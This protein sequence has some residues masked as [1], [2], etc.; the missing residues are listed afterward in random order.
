MAVSWFLD[1]TN[2]G[3]SGS[4]DND[5]VYGY[6]GHDT[7]T[8][9]AGNDMLYGGNDNDQFFGGDGNDTLL[10]EAGNDSLEGGA[11]SNVLDGGVGNDTLVGGS[12]GGNLLIGGAG[13]DT[14]VVYGPNDTVTELAGGGTDWV[15]VHFHGYTLLANQVENLRL[16][17]A[18]SAKGNS[19]NNRMV[20]NDDYSI[21]FDGGLG[22][23]TL[24]GGERND[25]LFGGVGNDSL[26]G[27]AGNDHLYG[28]V[29]NDILDGGIGADIMSGGL[30]ND[31]FIVD[32]ENDMV[33]DYKGSSGGVDT[34]MSSVSYYLDADEIENLVLTGSADID[35]DGHW[36]ANKIYGNDGN[37][38]LEG[39]GGKDSLYGGAG[40]D[41]FNQN[42]YGWGSALIDGGTGD[43][44]YYIDPKL[45]KV[46]EAA[47]AGT[48]TVYSNRDYTLLAN[49]ENLVLIDGAN[50]GKGN[51]VANDITACQYG[52]SSL[53]GMAGDDTLHGNEDD[54]LLD[55]G[56][57]IDSM[58]GGN[59]SDTYFV[60]N[61]DDEIVENLD[62]GW[63]EVRSASSYTLAEN[64]EILTL[65]GTGHIQGVGNLS[66][67]TITGNVGNNHLLGS[68]GND[69][70]YGGAGNDTLHG[71]NDD[72]RLYGGLGNDTIYGGDGYDRIWG[73][74]GNDYIDGGNGR[75]RLTGG[76][77][78]DT[79]IGG[80]D[81][82]DISG[83]D[84]NDR[85]DGS[86]GIG[87]LYGNAGDDYLRDSETD[88]D[89]DILKV[90]MD[91]G[92]G[93]DTLIG[94]SGS[95]S[96]YY[97]GTGNDYIDG[98]AGGDW[99]YGGDGND[100]Y[101]VDDLLDALWE[102]QYDP[103]DNS[104][105]QPS[106]GIDTVISSVSWSLWNGGN[107]F[108][109]L[110]LDGQAA[111]NLR[112]E[113]NGL[114]NRIDGDDG[115]NI[116]IG[117]EGNDVMYGGKGNDVFDGE[118]NDFRG[119][120]GKDTMYGGVGDDTY[121]ISP[122][123]NQWGQ[124]TIVELAGQGTD[125]VHSSGNY[126]LGA[127]LENLVLHWSGYG[128]G[129]E[130]NNDI[131]GGEFDYN[132]LYGMAGDDTL[133]GSLY[134]DTLDGGLDDDVM[135]GGEG[136]DVYYVD[137]LGDV[138]IEAV[139]DGNSWDSV[140]S[141]VSF[142][143]ADDD[144]DTDDEYLEGLT[145]IGSA[146]ID[147]SG[148]S[149]YNEIFGNSG[150]NHLSGN[151][152][153]DWIDGGAGNDTIE[154][155]A[156]AWSHFFGG[157]GN[158]SITGYGWF[159]AD[160]G[161]DTLIGLDGDEGNSMYGGLGNDSIVGASEN[162]WLTGDAGNDTLIGGDGD[163]YLDGGLGN[164]TM[165]GGTGGDSYLVNSSYD[166]VIE[167][168][169]D[170]GWDHVTSTINYVLADGVEGLSLSGTAQKGT[171]NDDSNYIN[172]NNV[173]NILD[174]KGGDDDINGGAGND[175]IFGGEGGDWIGGGLGKDSMVGGNGNDIYEVDDIGDKVVELV[176]DHSGY[177]PVFTDHLGHE[178]KGDA[179]NS[180][181]T[182]TLPANVEMLLL[183]G[184]GAINGTGNEAENVIVGN[185]F[186]NVLDGKAGD[187]TLYGGGGDDTY[188]LDSPDDIISEVYFTRFDGP[189]EFLNNIDAG[190]IDTV[191][192]TFD[193]DLRN[194]LN[195]IDGNEVLE[196]L[197]FVG[198]NAVTGHGNALDNVLVG[199]GNST[200]HGHEGD[201]TYILTKLSQ[202]DYD[203]AVELNEPGVDT[204]KT[205]MQG[206]ELGDNIENLIL[207]GNAVSGY[208]NT[209]NNELY[210]NDANNFLL[211]DEGDDLLQ[212]GK[213][214]DT[215]FGQDGNDTYYVDNISD[216]V[217]EYYMGDAPGGGHIPV[218]FSG[219]D[220]VYSSVSFVL[221]HFVEEL[222]LVGTG[223]I[224]GTGN[225]EDNT[226]VGNSRNNTLS[227]GEG[228]DIL[229]GKGG[230]D[231]LI[232]G[233]GADTF[234]FDAELN[235]INNIDTI[236]DF[237]TS[238]AG[239]IDGIE[240]SQS[241]FSSLSK[242]ILSADNFFKADGAIAGNDVDDYVIYNTT[243]GALYYDADGKGGDAA[244]QF[245]ILKNKPADLTADFFTV[246]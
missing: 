17:D 77:G 45:D 149:F 232:G 51:A 104:R 76:A 66:N 116:L 105:W 113:G 64:I 131:T 191:V 13:D 187:D 119:W 30:G 87:S 172:G 162:D 31:T 4:P 190:G 188:W 230:N 233:T 135:I 101:I 100:T 107:D 74:E 158:D 84:G 26:L 103:N 67:N 111:D 206:Y 16:V 78:N 194:D 62:E 29:G 215:L 195:L 2:D 1:D 91:G 138:V 38:R 214:A 11:G 50:I 58:I 27:N 139:D 189:P 145:L 168:A 80:I 164:D 142:A 184:N 61:E 204:V 177:D 216:K 75:S 136:D 165:V 28:D 48:D 193:Y 236:N 60:D 192:T 82:D 148:N 70:I 121:Y 243:T 227:G 55:G 126:T 241:I 224:N 152:G 143:L 96:I 225:V 222:R 179:V 197:T 170:D 43:D 171:G 25:T 3:F 72:D 166:A 24:E 245:A 52:K 5:I 199:N 213:G 44:V 112:G 129:N 20:G 36:L 37:N 242:G 159:S 178:H 150:N 210:G 200:L 175:T 122:L 211:G 128:K 209:L 212:G 124:D 81:R 217:W 114:N 173:N 239:E 154:G 147:G 90:Y 123:A 110:I 176:E 14:F 205:N 198:T 46:I 47:N 40:N 56:T 240:L 231:V 86:S 117:N 53:Y 186:N 106:G 71:Q 18:S 23:D 57:G 73:D 130:L 35:G 182:Y 12:S 49:F 144:P 203:I 141:S 226:L 42:S 34:V 6:G 97:G 155:L 120:E 207:I 161:N 8:G 89:Y 181:I 85:I 174:G 132:T 218:D 7:L 163:D 156:D 183:D 185:F 118:S 98:G 234:V 33:W 220:V 108:E 229:I 133:R 88:A 238:G 151:G 169:A 127:N 99:M 65:L 21:Y 140:I 32:D 68:D 94:G 19:L 196:N 137:S 237:T 202:D 79:I 125:T 180:Y 22:N 39:N 102:V 93:N 160:S 244:V 157:L 246:V 83:G 9:N 134:N 146:H 69:T 201:D 109:N 10:G 92:A 153:G 59:G 95:G 54:N 228:A 63:D 15:E 223:I 41:T 167:N 221:E 208:G 115:D 235:K 219:Y